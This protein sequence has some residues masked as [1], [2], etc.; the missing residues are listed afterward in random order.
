MLS[1]YRKSTYESAPFISGAGLDWCKPGQLAMQLGKQHLALHGDG[2]WF[3]APL[4][5]HE[6]L[7]GQHLALP[8]LS[9]V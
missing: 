9:A 6:K 3:A 2:D 8:L 5:Q 1:D 4:L 7:L